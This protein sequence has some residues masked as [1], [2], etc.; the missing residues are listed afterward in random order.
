MKQKI[1]NGYIYVKADKDE[2]YIIKGWRMMTKDK[3]KGYWA[4][5]ITKGLLENLRRLG[6]L[7]PEARDILAGMYKVQAAVDWER[8]KPDKNVKAMYKYPVKAKLYTHQT[9]AANMALMTFGIISPEGR[10]E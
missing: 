8:V 10:E 4:G 7:I 2:E 1:E 9:R 5:K 3:N 6:G